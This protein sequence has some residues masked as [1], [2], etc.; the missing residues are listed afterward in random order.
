MSLTIRRGAAADPP[1]FLLYGQEGIGKTTWGAGLP[2]SLTL[3]C[4]D[5]GGDLDYDRVDVDSWATM[6]RLVS[7]LARDAQGYRTIVIDSLSAL[8]RLLHAQLVD[9]A[10]VATIE[11]VG[12]GFGKGYTQ[13]AESWSALLRDLDLLRTKQRVAVAWL[14]HTDVKAFNDPNGPSYDRYQIRGHKGVVNATFGWVDACFFAGWDTTVRAEKRGRAADVT[15]VTKKGKA[16]AA[17]R[18]LWTAKE[19]GFDAKCRFDLPAEL[20]VDSQAFIKAFGWE[21]REARWRAG[22][23]PRK[24]VGE[25]FA[26]L[27]LELA[28]VDAYCVV[29]LGAPLAELD[30]AKAGELYKR[31][32]ADQALREQLGATPSATPAAPEAR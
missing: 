17:A 4:E 24:T 14:G 29:H 30:R 18:R 6:R 13:A 10:G 23:A 21:E 22:L 32:S 25:A 31:V 9:D 5:G 7:E 19:P 2:G 15:D 26:A 27:G 1:R 8:E 3:S 11:D 16:A 20:P 28:L 12:G